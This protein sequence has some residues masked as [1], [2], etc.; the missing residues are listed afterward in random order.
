MS[1]CFGFPAGLLHVPYDFDYFLAEG[2]SPLLYFGIEAASS[3]KSFHQLAFAGDLE[4]LSFR[5]SALGAKIRMSERSEFGFLSLLLAD[6]RKVRVSGSETR[7]LRETLSGAS[8]SVPPLYSV[9][10]FSSINFC[11]DIRIPNF[12]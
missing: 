3:G 2:P 1:L 8:P 11:S 9:T 7:K 4:T 5:E 10:I 6:L 12:A